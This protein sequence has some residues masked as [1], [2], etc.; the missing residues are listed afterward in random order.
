MISV[1]S[2]N[3]EELSINKRILAKTKIENNF[4]EILSK[5]IIANKFSNEEIYSINNTISHS[6]PFHSNDDFNNS[7]KILEKHISKKNKILVIG[8]YDVDGCVSTSLLINFFKK[9]NIK[10]DYFIPNRIKN[11]YGVNLDLIEYLDQK[12]KPDLVFMLDCGSNSSEP[13][14]YLKK[15][16][17]ECLVIDHHNINKPYPEATCIINPKKECNYNIY[18]YYCS[19]YL[20]FLFLD[21]FIKKNSLKINLD[22]FH[23]YVALATIADVMPLRK[24]NRFFLQQTIKNFDLNNNLVFKKIFQIKKIKKKLDYS[25]L[26]FLIAPM[27]NSAGRIND[28]NI[29]VKLLTSNNE[30]QIEKIVNKIDNLNERRKKIQNI[31]LNNINLNEYI[32]DKGIIFIDNIDIHEGI[33]G[34]IASKIKELFNK[35]CIV[36]SKSN[37]TYK[38]SARSSHDF[39]IGNLIKTCIDKSIVISG[40]GHNLAAGLNIKKES[41]N[42]L[43]QF[44]NNQYIKHKSIKK[45]LYVSK[46]SFSSLNLKFL[47]EILKLEPFG[48]LNEKPLFLV[49][50]IKIMNSSVINNKFITLYLKQSS[51]RLIKAISFNPIQSKI[52]DYLLN[53]VKP[54]NLI[55]KIDKNNWNNKTNIQI[56]IVDIIIPNKA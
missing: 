39:N 43:K 15:K 22:D 47:D 19:A 4:S 21:V 56:E 35:P 20:T 37:L 25:D 10:A 8:D 36:F 26:A 48:N 13:I 5:I 14:K 29:I 49:E 16:K 7:C 28:A 1:S 12:F 18:D 17:I 11:G 45:N 38:G 6:N 30:D 41:I 24:N 50:N 27:F 52:S 46:I 34:I 23:I 33:I 40:G 53:Y 2:K 9:I 55:L 31:I 42:K 3:W 54:V 44:L 32:L 51:K